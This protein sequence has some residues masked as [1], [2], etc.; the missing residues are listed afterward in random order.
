MSQLSD[1]ILI[2]VLNPLVIDAQTFASSQPNGGQTIVGVIE[3]QLLRAPSHQKY[4]ISVFVDALIR[5]RS[6]FP[7]KAQFAQNLE[8]IYS[9]S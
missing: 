8:R 6:T 3:S 7:F 1:P 4:A 2:E 5:A 9:V